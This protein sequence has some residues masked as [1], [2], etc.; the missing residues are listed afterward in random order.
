MDAP[1]GDRRDRALQIVAMFN[2]TTGYFLA[3][4][5]LDAMDAG[6]IDDPDNLER[7]KRLLE[8]IAR[9]ATRRD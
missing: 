8:R 9:A 4:R 3:Q 1:A 6:R 7:Q 5:A 2:A